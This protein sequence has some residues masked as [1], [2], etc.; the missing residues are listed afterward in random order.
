[1]NKALTITVALLLALSG[2]HLTVSAHYCGGKLHASSLT[3]NGKVS[4][5]A[6]EES[7]KPL[8]ETTLSSHCCDIE[9][10]VFSVDNNYSPSDFHFNHSFLNQVTL[11]LQ[12][13]FVNQEHYTLQSNTF[14]EPP[15]P[16]SVDEIH[17]ADLCVFRI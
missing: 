16:Y 14:R 3:F 11:V 2:M 5:C 17:P 1:M 10:H 4:S 12:W 9:S 15:G 8:N 7:G 6:M 13:Q